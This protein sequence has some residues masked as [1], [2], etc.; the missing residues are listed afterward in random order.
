MAIGV[1]I[2][3]ILIR[4]LY[5]VDSVSLSVFLDSSF[6]VGQGSAHVNIKVLGRGV[7]E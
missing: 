2:G 7:T 4:V 3:H 1:L 6:A 5:E